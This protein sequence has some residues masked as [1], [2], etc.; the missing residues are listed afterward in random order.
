MNFVRKVA[1]RV[2]RS[3]DLVRRV[4]LESKQIFGYGGENCNSDADDDYPWWLF[5]PVLIGILVG[6]GLL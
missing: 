3:S 5:I 1:G 4:V 6:L 2:L